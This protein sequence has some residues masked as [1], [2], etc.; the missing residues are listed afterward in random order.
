M[1]Q[2]KYLPYAFLAPAMLAMLALVFY[3]LLYGIM[4]SFTNATSKNI[5]K[6][7]GANYI[8]ASYDFVGLDQFKAIL[9]P[10]SPF[11]GVLQQTVIWTVINVVLHVSLGLLLGVL[12][13]RKIRGR[14]VYRVLLIIPWAVPSFVSA[15]AWRYIFN[16]QFGFINLFLGKLGV[17]P[18]GWL[19]TQFLATTVA[20]IANTWLAIPFNMVTILG[21]LQ[22][23]PTDLYEAANVDGASA[24]QSFRRIT[25]P[26]LRPILTTIILLGAIWT[27]NSFNIIFLLTAGEPAGKTE[28]LATYA[29]RRAFENYNFGVSAAYSVI[30]LIILL[31]FAAFYI[32]VINR[33]EQSV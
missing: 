5:A 23:I 2:R 8:P 28:I 21:G 14:T 31:A 13:N 32:R 19:S 29:Y 27:F 30:I 33:N 15:F 10:D 17:A 22:S 7:I 11:W 20:V 26:L 18:V 1:T 3:P 16:Q 9:Q 6:H 25:L 24:W 12:L 4:F